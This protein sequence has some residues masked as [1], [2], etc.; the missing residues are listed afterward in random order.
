MISVA[1]MVMRSMVERLIAAQGERLRQEQSQSKARARP[2][3]SRSKARAKPEQSQS[4]NRRLTHGYR[5]CVMMRKRMK[6]SRGL[7]AA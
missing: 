6:V 7:V 1:Q 5:M 3:Q 4:N 2:E